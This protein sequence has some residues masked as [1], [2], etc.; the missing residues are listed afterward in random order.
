MKSA[1]YQCSCDKITEETTE[2]GIDLPVTIICT[3]GKRARRIYGTPNIQVPEGRLGNAKMDTRTLKVRT[4]IPVPE[5]VMND[6][7]LI[8]AVKQESVF[9]YYHNKTVGKTYAIIEDVNIFKKTPRQIERKALEKIKVKFEPNFK[10]E[11]QYYN[12]LLC[13]IS[14]FEDT[15]YLDRVNILGLYE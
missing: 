14:K 2:H 6:L 10:P 12:T 15:Y 7:V 11:N 8:L 9:C 1:D 3:C 5:F 4:N 13:N